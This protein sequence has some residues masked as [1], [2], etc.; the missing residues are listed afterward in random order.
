M[1]WIDF[2]QAIEYLFVEILFIPLDWLR[3]LQ[4]E[5]WWLANMV[6][7]VF[8]LTG[9]AAF[10][11]WMVQLNGFREEEKENASHSAH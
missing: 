4:F 3:N 1:Q 11:Y 8:I 7:W 6:S 9:A 10:I 5:S 2:W